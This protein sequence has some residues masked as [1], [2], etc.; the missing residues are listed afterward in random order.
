MHGSG[1]MHAHHSHGNPIKADMLPRLRDSSCKLA[2]ACIPTV[3]CSD[4]CGR[5]MRD[6]VCKMDVLVGA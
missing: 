4:G 5:L 1:C 6:P 3:A 2:C